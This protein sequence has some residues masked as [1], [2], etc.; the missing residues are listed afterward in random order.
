M[1]VSLEAVRSSSGSALTGASRPHRHVTLGAAARI[2]TLVVVAAIFLF[3]LVTFLLAAFRTRESMSSASPLAGLSW[4]NLGYDWIQIR[5]FGSGLFTTW[6]E[7]S[8]LVCAGGT[9][10]SLLSSIPAGY[11]LAKLRVPLRRTILV[12]TLLMMVIPNT[13]LV[14]PLF[15][16]VTA[17]HQLGQLWP[18]AVIF[19]FFPFGTYLAFIHFDSAL[20]RELIEAA[21][22]D[23]VSEIGIF[24][25]VALPVSKQAIAI[26]AFFAFLADWTNYFL[27]LVLLP[28]SNQATL[29]VG[30]QQLITG[31]QLYDPSGAAG[32][33]V[34]LYMPQLV[35]AAAAQTA[36]LLVIFLVA[37]RFLSRGATV[38]AVKQ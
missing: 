12:I 22:I 32:S 7:N 10:L 25:R 13:V 36:P 31:S 19:G 4:G 20:P 21:R 35:F 18:L 33:P 28:V 34:Q 8:L 15:L 38:G 14:I 30:L 16:E 11:A 23:G 1:N 5:G 6:Y 37:Q 3:L 26:V 9:A 24:T 29:T 27:P 2:A 17:L